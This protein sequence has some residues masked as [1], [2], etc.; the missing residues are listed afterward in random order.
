MQSVQN[1]DKTTK[2]QAFF[3]TFAPCTQKHSITELSFR[4]RCIY[5]IVMCILT[6]KLRIYFS[7]KEKTRSVS[8]RMFLK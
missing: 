1:G 3:C 8:E 5:L 7:K 2:Y 6:A 4:I